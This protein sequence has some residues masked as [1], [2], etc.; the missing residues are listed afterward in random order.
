MK[1][2]LAKKEELPRLMELYDAARAFMRRRG[3]MVQWV[4]GYPSRELVAVGIDAGEQWVCVVDDRV[5]V[6]FWFAVGPD[7][8][9]AE[10]WEGDDRLGPAGAWLDDEGVPYGVV[11]RLASDGSVRGVGA[12][13]LE[14]CLER[15]GNIRVDTHACNAVMQSLLARLGYTRCGVIYLPDGSPRDAFQKLKVEN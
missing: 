14:W 3:N 10:I 11:H 12:F 7:L 4:G 5:V 8:T 2:R 6:T 15:C 1:I 13:C 9:Y